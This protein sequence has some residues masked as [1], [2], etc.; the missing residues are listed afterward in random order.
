MRLQFALV[1][2][3]CKDITPRKLHLFLD[4]IQAQLGQLTNAVSATYF[5]H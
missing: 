4:K 2:G 1:A 3:P 5:G